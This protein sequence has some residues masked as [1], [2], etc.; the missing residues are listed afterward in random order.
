[1]QRI[2]HFYCVGL[3]ALTNLTSEQHL[4]LQERFST[5]ITPFFWKNV[6]HNQIAGFWTFVG[7]RRGLEW[8]VPSARQLVFW[9]IL[10]CLA[11]SLAAWLIANQQGNFNAQGL[12]SYV[13][14]P[15]L[16]LIAGIFI[17]QKINLPKV[18]L[19]PAILWLVLDVHVAIIQSG[20]QFLSTFNLL[21]VLV[22]PI[23]PPL[24]LVLFIWQSLAVV[25]IFSKLLRWAWW[26]RVLILVA[27]LF[28][29]VVWQ[30]TSK[31]Q[32]IWKIDEILPTLPEQV[33]YAQPALLN[34]T[35]DAIQLNAK[36]QTQWYFLGIAGVDYQNVF[37]SE[38]E[39]MKEQFDVRF[40]TLGFSA[41]LIN[42]RETATTHAFATK[43]S[44][45][46]ALKRIGQRMN[47]EN[48]VLFLYMTSH[49]LVNQ[50]ELAQE[51]LDLEDI[52]PQWLRQALDEANIRWRVIVVSACYSGSFI[53]A[54]QSPD[55]LIITASASDKASFGCTNEADYTYFGRAFMDEAMREKSSL[56][57]AFE[58]AQATVQ[59][60][61]TA[62]GL[63][64]SQ[65][66]WSIGNNMQLILPQFEQ[67]LFPQHRQAVTATPSATPTPV[68]LL[69]PH[70]GT[71]VTKQ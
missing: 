66:Q 12:V 62:Q 64:P 63:E 8:V 10:G 3:M 67:Q 18:A 42:N 68:P 60:W 30:S 25:W 58:Q 24:F 4:E 39:R 65:P 47:R 33:L 61:E 31:T 69:N 45:S 44:I 14:W 55:T 50:F 15:F 41:E 9:G 6:W 2:Y 27:T 51:A 48:D 59:Q 54:L 22:Y 17:A 36:S 19:I 37:R 49:G 52:D 29:L 35:L 23:L 11:N 56:K 43:T 32:P 70:L 34:Q 28:T 40:G 1:M 26:E 13:L 57:A 7:S 53:P 38:I 71:E 46:Q 5:H 21:P 16:A 20:L